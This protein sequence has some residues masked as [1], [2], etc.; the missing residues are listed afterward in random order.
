MTVASNLERQTLNRAEIQ[1]VTGLS[2]DAVLAKIK[3]GELPN[4]GSQRR[5]LVPRSAV[6]RMLSGAPQ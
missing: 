5:I 6:E 2:R 1:A 4:I 3:T